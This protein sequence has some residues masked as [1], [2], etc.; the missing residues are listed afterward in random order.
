MLSQYGITHVI[1]CAADYSA[2]YFND[3]SIT[4]KKYHLKDHVRE[5]IECIFYDAIQFIEEA[6]NQNGKV[7]VHCVQ[8]VSRSATVCLAYLIY[9]QKLSFNE[10]L[11]YLKEK[12]PIANPNMTFIA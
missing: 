5:Q 12:R 4:Y 11:A 1:N 8:G 10:G 2:N 6:R 9:K 7:Y 3:D